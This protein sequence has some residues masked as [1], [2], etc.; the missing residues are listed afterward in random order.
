MVRSIYLTIFI[1]SLISIF[2]EQNELQMILTSFGLGLSINLGYNLI[3]Q[4]YY[5]VDRSVVKI[6]E[7]AINISITIGVIIG[8]L[9]ISE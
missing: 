9:D 5:F 7:G 4:I 1:L 6:Y 3:N 2:I 8:I